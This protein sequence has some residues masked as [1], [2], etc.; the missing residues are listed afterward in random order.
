MT[1]QIHDDEVSEVMCE[2]AGGR[3]MTPQ[4]TLKRYKLQLES[5]Q[6]WPAGEDRERMIQWVL[7]KIKA[8][9]ERIQ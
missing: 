3:V 1:I 8:T 4:E 7:R 2:L 6:N 5:L 9:K